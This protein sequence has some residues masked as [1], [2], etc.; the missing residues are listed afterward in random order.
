MRLLLTRARDQNLDLKKKLEKSG[1]Q[2]ELFPLI[3]IQKP[4][5]GAKALQ[6]SLHHIADYQWLIL[7]SVPAVKAVAEFLPSPP[8]KLKIVVV[9][10]KTAEMA[11]QLGWKIFS[12]EKSKGGEGLISFFEKQKVR[13]EKI[14]Y[15][16]SSIGREELV[17]ALQKMGVSVDV[18]EAYQTVG[19]GKSGDDLKKVLQQGIDAVLFFSPS[20]VKQFTTLISVDDSL[21]QKILFIPFGETTATALQE[22][23]LRADFVPSQSSEDIFVS[24]LKDFLILRKLF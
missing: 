23:H 7:T 16:R 17:V 12:P 11:Q 1:F 9:G 4:S 10:P 2:V 21:L 19:A 14:L 15:P 5:D 13:G 18:V 3:E 8:E 6:K 24:E 20:A 22:N